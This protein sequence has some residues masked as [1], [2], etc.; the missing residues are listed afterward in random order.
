MPD[1]QLELG[2]LAEVGGLVSQELE[3]LAR[4]LSLLVLA[5]DSLA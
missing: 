3:A 4:G 2:S 1:L 5:R